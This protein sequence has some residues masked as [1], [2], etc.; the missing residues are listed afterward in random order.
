MQSYEISQTGYD[1]NLDIIDDP[2]GECFLALY[3]RRGLYSTSEAETLIKSYGKLVSSFA[4]TPDID[5]DEAYMYDSD[6]VGLVLDFS[7]G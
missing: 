2:E 3:V 5:C 4:A 1:L 6:D 7:Q